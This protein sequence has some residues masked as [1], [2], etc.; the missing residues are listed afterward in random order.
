[1]AGFESDTTLA[2]GAEREDQATT[3]PATHGPAHS[4][5]ASGDGAESP[6]GAAPPEEEL[7]AVTAQRDQYLA[8]AQRT[9]ADFENYRKRVARDAATAHERG[10]IKL[11]RELLP[12][13]DNLD[14]ALEE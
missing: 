14:R 7:V 4:G 11:G 10:V 6:G 5:P 3:A 2:D 1:M 9:Q 13:L 12:V 8:L